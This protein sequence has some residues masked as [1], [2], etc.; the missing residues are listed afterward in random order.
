M[1]TFSPY[2]ITS[3]AADSSP[4]SPSGRLCRRKCRQEESLPPRVAASWLSTAHTSQYVLHFKSS[5]S[6]SRFPRQ[7]PPRAHTL[8][9]RK[10]S[11][12]PWL[13]PPLTPEGLCLPLPQPQAPRASDTLTLLN[14]PFPLHCLTRCPSQ[15]LLWKCVFS[16]PH[17]MGGPSFSA[18][19]SCVCTPF[20]RPA[21]PPKCTASRTSISR[22]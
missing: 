9:C 5:C 8:F 6:W 12:Q 1:S 11:E 2:P 19:S 17:D 22:S 16:W 20:R 7:P 4:P 13:P 18:E 14:T 10:T 3:S 15:S 21:H